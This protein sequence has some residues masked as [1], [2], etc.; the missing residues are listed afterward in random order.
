MQDTGAERARIAAL[1]AELAKTTGDMRF[2]L[3]AGV[4]RGKR[5]GRPPADD[6]AA[7]A[8]AESLI[9]AGL[10]RS[11]NAACKR[12]ASMYSHAGSEIDKHATD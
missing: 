12:A 7:L 9:V 3:A 4:L 6:T 11:R 5:G 8:F 10:A 2:S 1:A